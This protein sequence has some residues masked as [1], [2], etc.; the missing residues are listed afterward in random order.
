MNALRQAAQAV[1]RTVV[2]TTVAVGSLAALLEVTTHLPSQGRSSPFYHTLCDTLGM[3]LLQRLDPETAHN[4]SI[5][6]VKNGWAPRANR[7]SNNSVDLSTTLTFRNGSQLTFDHPL[8]LAAGYDKDGECIA[9]LWELGWASVE[10][11]TVTPLPQPGNP[12]P[13]LFRLWDDQAIIN[14]YGFNSAGSAQVQENVKAY[15]QSPPPKPDDS[16]SLLSR[17]FQSLYGSVPLPTGGILGVNIGKNKSTEADDMEA[18]RNDYTHLISTLGE[19]ADYLVINVSSP[20][21]A[22]LRDLQN[23]AHLQQLLSS[24]LQ[25]RDELVHQPPVL[26][27]LAPDL[28]DDELQSIADSC[29]LAKVDGV[30][31]TNT[32]NQRP[33]TLKSP[34]QTET[35]GLSGRPLKEI[36]TNIIRKLYKM[37]KGELPL[38]GVGGIASGQDAY[39]KL[40]AGA[41][42]VQLYSSLVYGGPGLVSSIRTELQEIMKLNGHRSI[43]DVV[44]LDHEDLFWKKKRMEAAGLPSAAG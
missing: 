9:E 7:S 15:R 19:F 31:V 35:G 40:R 26:V 8:G 11:G 20:N 6:A 44:G 16:S 28:T 34:Q 4:L 14:R 22:G 18:V 29:L 5:Y 33:S 43:E 10:I 32:T 30:I 2:Q 13:R 21:T 24:C 25:A 1:R 42:V 41:S 23:P 12:Q 38:I 3:A 37:T 27:K 17:L 39:E 36:S